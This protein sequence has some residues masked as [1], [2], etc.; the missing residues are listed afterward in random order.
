APLLPEEFEAQLA[1]A[2][3]A[4]PDD[5]LQYWLQHGHGPV[6]HGER[7]A[8]AVLAAG[9][10]PLST[11]VAELGRHHR[12]AGAVPFV[13]RLVGALALPPRRLAHRELPLGGYADVTTRGAPEHVLP[14]QLALEPEEFLRR[15]AQ[16]E[17]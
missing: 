3:P 5:V 15:F 6:A 9:S 16:G 17:L 2:L 1:W 12:L 13:A 14:V 7:L 4:W 10:R 8:G 11:V